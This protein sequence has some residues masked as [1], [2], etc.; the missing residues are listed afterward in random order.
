MMRHWFIGLFAFMFLVEPTFAQ[1]TVTAPL[2]DV[3]AQVAVIKQKAKLVYIDRI[4]QIYIVSTTNQLYK[5]AADGKLLATANFNYNG[6]I[7]ALDITNPLEVYVFYQELNRVVFLDNN[8]AFRGAIDLQQ[9]DVHMALAIARNYANGLWVFDASDL[10]IKKIDKDG[11]IT[12]TSGNIRQFTA[13]NFTPQNMVDNGNLVYISDSSKNM[14]VF[15]VFANYKKELP[16]TGLQLQ[17]VGSNHLIAAASTKINYYKLKPFLLTLSITLAEPTQAFAGSRLI[18][19]AKEQ[20]VVV[21][22]LHA[23]TLID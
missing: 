20:E 4:E 23:N 22:K 18:C 12:Q 10:M 17:Q 7:T 5:Y 21:Y 9:S 13:A 2:S 15:D 19:L 3:S 8:L 6:N 1:T 16:I 11:T 14:L